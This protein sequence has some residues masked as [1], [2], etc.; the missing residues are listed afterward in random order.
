MYVKHLSCCTVWTLSS[1]VINSV[2][3]RTVVP[4]R[5]EKCFFNARLLNGG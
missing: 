1:P 5:K 2:G 4:N 3:Y